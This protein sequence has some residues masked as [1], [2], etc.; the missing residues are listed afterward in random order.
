MFISSQLK[1]LWFNH[2]VVTLYLFCTRQFIVSCCIWT[3][4]WLHRTI[5]MVSNHLLLVCQ[6]DAYGRYGTMPSLI[7]IMC[8]IQPVPH[9]PAMKRTLFSLKTMVNNEIIE[10]L[11]MPTGKHNWSSTVAIWMQQYMQHSANIRKQSMQ[12]LTYYNL[13]I[14]TH[15]T[16]PTSTFTSHK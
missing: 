6:G 10:L 13:S 12:Q 3:T 11:K 1:I 7:R 8:L 15:H 14:T 2:R 5:I 4:S 9:D 16:C